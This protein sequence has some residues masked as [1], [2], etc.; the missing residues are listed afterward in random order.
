ML[1]CAMMDGSVKNFTLHKVSFNKNLEIFNIEDYGKIENVLNF[2]DEKIDFETLNFAIVS[3][4]S[5]VNISGIIHRNSAGTLKFAPYK[6][7]NGR[8][9]FFALKKNLQH[10]SQIQFDSVNDVMS[11]VML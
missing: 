5:K 8:D 1:D 2:N 4:E 6:G 9:V 7:V 3:A 11:M 10:M